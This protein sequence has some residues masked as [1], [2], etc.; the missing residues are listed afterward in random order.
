VIGKSRHARFWD[1]VVYEHHAYE[2]LATLYANI[3]V[4]VGE[5][6]PQNTAA[7]GAPSPGTFDAGGFYTNVETNQIP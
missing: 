7:N 6:G 1:N 2:T 4:I 5:Y 3:P